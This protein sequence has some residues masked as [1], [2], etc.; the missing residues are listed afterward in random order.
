ME[1][2]RIA[3][4]LES[5]SKAVESD[6]TKGPATYA[7]ATATILTGLKCTVRGPAG[8]QLETDMPTSMGGE[9]SWPNPGWFFRASIA[10][11]CATMIASRAARLGIELAEL[12][13]KVVGDGNHRG[14]LGLDKNISAGHSALRTDVRISARNASPE[15]L[16]ELVTWA[17]EHSPVG[18]TVRDAPK[19]TLTIGIV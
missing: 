14:I 2:S 10:A 6:P 17:E 4:T 5:L 1:G 16:R 7:A 19:N 3:T 9:N 12:E 11:C 18:R 15:K 8:E 13:V